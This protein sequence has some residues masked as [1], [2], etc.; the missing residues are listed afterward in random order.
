MRAAYDLA[1]EPLAYED[2]LEEDQVAWRAAKLYDLVVPQSALE[3]LGDAPA[4]G[5]LRVSGRADGRARARGAG[6]AEAGRHQ[7]ARVPDRV[8]RTVPRLGLGPARRVARHR[9]LSAGRVGTAD[10]GRRRG[11]PVRRASVALGVR[12]LITRPVADTT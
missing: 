5:G 4:A 1:A 7:P 2:D 6:A 8:G 11:L 12:S 10:P 9:A 3:V